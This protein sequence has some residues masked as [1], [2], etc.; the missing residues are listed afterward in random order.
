MV[1]AS[2]LWI[3]G[4]AVCSVRV[5]ATAWERFRGLLGQREVLQPMWFPSTSSV[6]T[7]GMQVAI[8]VVYVGADHRVLA[9]VT[10][11]PWRLGR[12]RRASAVL[13]GPPG[14]AKD[15]AIEPGSRVEIRP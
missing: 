4:V 10:M 3:D 15:W 6:H 9:V 11:R 5:A 12:P 8:D 7:I 14:M 2:T 1:S 13:E